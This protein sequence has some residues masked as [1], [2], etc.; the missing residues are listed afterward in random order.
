MI[1]APHA[2]SPS[3]AT[4]ENTPVRGDPTATG[5]RRFIEPF[6]IG[7]E[8]WIPHKVLRFNFNQGNAMAD[9]EELRRDPNNM[10]DTFCQTGIAAIWQLSELLAYMCAFETPCT[11]VINVA[12]WHFLGLFGEPQHF[13]ALQNLNAIELFCPEPFR[14]TDVWFARRVQHPR[15]GLIPPGRRHDV[16]SV[17]EFHYDTHACHGRT[18]TFRFGRIA[19]LVGQEP[20]SPEVDYEVQDMPPEARFTGRYDLMPEVLPDNVTPEG[21]NSHRPAPMSTAGRRQSG[22]VW[23]ELQR[24]VRRALIRNETFDANVSAALRLAPNEMPYNALTRGDLDDARTAAVRTAAADLRHEIEALTRA[25]EDRPP[26]IQAAVRRVLDLVALAEHHV[27]TREAQLT[28]ERDSL[29]FVLG[30]FDRAPTRVNQRLRRQLRE[31]Q[32]QSSQLSSS[33]LAQRY[34]A[35]VDR[36]HEAI[37]QRDELLSLVQA[38]G[39]TVPFQCAPLSPVTDERSKT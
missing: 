8:R 39:L 36:L 10:L 19:R 18:N 17:F 31:L 4:Y 5:W 22:A 27:E 14:N 32:E 12:D 34:N 38:E 9:P 33:V 23:Q 13:R 7:G 37:R 30:L 6:A 11:I 20:M 2:V 24:A 35:L 3:S 26:E 25:A 15:R 28:A 21:G 29:Q 16:P 1:F